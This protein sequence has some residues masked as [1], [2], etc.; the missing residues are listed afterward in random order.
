MS[1]GEVRRIVIACDVQ[2]EIDL[3]VRKATELAGRWRVPVHGVFLQN[4]NLRRLAGLPLGRPVS[5]SRPEAAQ[6]FDAGDLDTLFSAL[7]AGMQRALA[8]AAEEEGL[9]WS[10][11]ELRDVPSAAGALLAEGDLLVVEAGVGG[12]AGSW[13]PRSHWESIAGDLGGMVL[14]R[15]GEVAERRRVVLMIGAAASD[16]FR[17]FDAARALARPRDESTLLLLAPS[18]AKP[19]P[20]LAR[21]LAVRGVRPASI[22]RVAG[23]T[24]IRAR[25]AALAPRL[26]IV[27]TEALD[28]DALRLLIAETRCDLLLIG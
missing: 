21:A 23:A 22:E 18:D 27:E 5:L 24:A 28:A 11:A 10:F 3:A 20:A 15:R 12:A 25:I 14:L 17:A 8:A 7:A 26:V 4:E 9:D 6:S 16:H 19:D 13:R 1:D 2:D